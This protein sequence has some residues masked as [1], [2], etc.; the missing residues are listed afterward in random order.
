[1]KFNPKH[2]KMSPKEKE[3]YDN[4]MEM[5]KNLEDDI[6]LVD[7]TMTNDSTKE[8]GK[9]NEKGKN[10][11]SNLSEAAIT[12]IRICEKALEVKKIPSQRSSFQRDAEIRTTRRKGS[13]IFLEKVVDGYG[14]CLIFDKLLKASYLV[15]KILQLRLS[16]MK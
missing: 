8:D 6:D 10:K 13:Q 9:D 16:F 4:K 2:I 12:M 11:G 1:M 7:N 14:E 15:S 5:N 3:T